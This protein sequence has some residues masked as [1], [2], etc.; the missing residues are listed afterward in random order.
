MV[1]IAITNEGFAHFEFVICNHEA[2]ELACLEGREM[3]D[4]NS[5]DHS[6]Y[7]VV[8]DIS[9]ENEHIRAVA[10]FALLFDVV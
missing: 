4:P 9:D 2:I 6:L 1:Y 7:Y 3:A 10:A 8:V 5:P